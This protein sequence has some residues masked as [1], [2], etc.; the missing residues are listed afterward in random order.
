MSGI[1]KAYIAIFTNIITALKLDTMNNKIYD[2]RKEPTATKRNFYGYPM[3][4]FYVLIPTSPVLLSVSLL[5]TAGYHQW[6]TVC[7]PQAC[8]VTS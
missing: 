7:T 5:F 4:R 3:A 6:R 1:K 2:Q 8:H